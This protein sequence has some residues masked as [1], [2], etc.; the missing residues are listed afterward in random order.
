[1][2]RPRNADIHEMP[3]RGDGG[4]SH[5]ASAR[6]WRSSA[7]PSTVVATPRA[8]GRSVTRSG[9]PAPAGGPPA[10]GARTQG[11]PSARPQPPAGHRGHL[12]GH[13]ERGA[14]LPRR[15]RSRTRSTSRGSTTSGRRRPTSP[16]LGQIAA[17]VPIIAE[18]V[19]EDVFPSP[20]RSSA[21]AP[22]SCSRWSVTRWST[23]PSATAT[24]WS[25]V[26]SPPRTT[27]TSWP[28]C[29]TTRRP[30]RRSSARTARSGCCPTT[31]R[32]HPS[33]VT[34][35]TILGKVTAVLR[36]I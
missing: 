32:S 34:H 6:C 10:L 21:R 3:D 8:C 2:A 23:R 19:V 11:L 33:T 4:R 15:Y 20:A 14:R 16:V 29:S 18:E 30:S 35:A 24:G 5:T 1:M 17:G 12:P 7:T 13:T 26:S 36:R 22:S 25:S 31:R 27:A 9:S 28:P